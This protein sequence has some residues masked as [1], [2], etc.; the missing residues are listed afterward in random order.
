MMD[1]LGLNYGNYSFDEYYGY[2]E[3]D[4]CDPEEGV[5]LGEVF[6]P[7]LYS[8]TFI[9]GILGNRLLLGVL[10]KR[11]KIWSVTDTFILHLAVADI[12]LLVTLPFWVAEVLQLKHKNITT[13]ECNKYV[14]AFLNR[15]VLSP[16]LKESRHFSKC[17]R[18]QGCSRAKGC[19]PHGSEPGTEDLEELA[20]GRPEGV[21]GGLE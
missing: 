4:I 14:A 6:I 13:I 7:I 15:I 9:V 3:G 12:L 16:F 19:D 5:K 8:V 17:W 10:I 20:A 2:E 11:R 18:D 21:G 1:D